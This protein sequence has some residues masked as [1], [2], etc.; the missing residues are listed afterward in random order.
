LVK[1]L[2]YKK[3]S[4]KNDVGFYM[5]DDTSDSIHVYRA[6][7]HDII[8]RGGAERVDVS[9]VQMLRWYHKRVDL[10]KPTLRFSEFQDAFL[11][12]APHYYHYEGDHRDDTP[13]TIITPDM[14]T[15]PELTVAPGPGHQR[16]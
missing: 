13:A 14:S 10:R 3:F 15:D 1:G 9:D 6:Y 7:Y 11:E 8:Q 12:L 4:L 5:G 2:E 16:R